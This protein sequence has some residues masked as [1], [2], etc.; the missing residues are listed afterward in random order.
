MY[1]RIITALTIIAV[2]SI[3]VFAATYNFDKSAVIVPQCKWITSSD[4][5]V[6]WVDCAESTETDYGYFLKAGN[7]TITVIEDG[8]PAQG[9]HFKEADH[10]KQQG[11]HSRGGT[12]GFPCGIRTGAE[13]DL[14]RDRSGGY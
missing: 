7:T 14:Q 1:R 9:K 10:E 2:L 3:P 5:D 12:C 4:P 13:R 6:I 8:N 11:S